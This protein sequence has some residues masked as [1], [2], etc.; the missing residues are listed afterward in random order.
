MVDAVRIRRAGMWLLRF[1]VTLLVVAV[2]VAVALWM[3]DRYQL[4]P[5]TRDGRVRAD[6]VSVSP[7][8]SGFVTEIRVRDNQFVHKG[9][10]LFVLDPARFHLAVEQSAAAIENDRAAL[11]EAQREAKRNDALGEL[12]SVE[13]RQQSHAKV[14]QLKAALDQAIVEHN[15]A[16]LNLE[17]STV[18]A[19]VNGMVTNLELRPGDYLTTGRQGL[20]LVDTDSLYVDG[21]FE[22]TKLPRIRVGDAAVVR[23]MGQPQLLYGHVDSIAFAI[24]DR[25]RTPS[26]NLIANV[27][28]T[29]SWVRL[30]Q[31]IPVRVHIDKA[32]P[33]VLLIAGRT[34]TVTVLSRE[35]LHRKHYWWDMP[36]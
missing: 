33:N 23:L 22:E 20:A 10:V 31:R 36:L 3:W 14:D 25:E 29:F 8:V 24:E 28:P 11:T 16:L 27:N 9:D 13:I 34:A 35:A 4:Q 5:W 26:G 1:V 15:T 17:R 2:A 7:D 12:V 21:Y 18:R 32:P 30:A 6:V 19:L